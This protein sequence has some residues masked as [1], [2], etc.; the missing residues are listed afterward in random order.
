VAQRMQ[1]GE[2]FSEENYMRDSAFKRAT[3]FHTAKG[4][5]V[6]SGGGIMPDIFVPAD[7]VGNTQLVQEMSDQQLFNAYVI[8]KLQ[9]ALSG[10]KTEDSFEQ[11]YNISNDQ[12]DDFILYSSKTLKEMNSAEVKESRDMIKLLIKAFAARY[13]W[14]DNAYFQVLNSDDVTLK[15]AIAAM[16]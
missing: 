6:Y 10:Y 5:K 3:V 13:K 15:K 11:H 12:V 8:D 9:P 16:N 1:K 7:T 4:R 14:G 2:L